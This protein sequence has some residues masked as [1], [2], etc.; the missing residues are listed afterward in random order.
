VT[1]ISLSGIG[2]PSGFEGLSFRASRADNP[3]RSAK[4]RGAP[5]RDLAARLSKLVDSL[6]RLRI[7]ARAAPGSSGIGGFL[8]FESLTSSTSL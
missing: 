7:A 2:G 6:G 1:I 8:A 5:L 4:P 3:L